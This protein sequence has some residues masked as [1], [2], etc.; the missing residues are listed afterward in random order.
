[1]THAEP[2]M[3]RAAHSSSGKWFVFIAVFIDMVGIGIAFPVLPILVGEYTTSNAEQTHWAIALS[4]VYSLMQFLCAPL[5]GAISDRFG[6]RIVLIAAIVG[7]GL[8]YVLIAHGAVA[9]DHAHRPHSWRGDR[10]ELFGRECLSRRH[11]AARGARQELRSHRR[12]VRPR[13]HLRSTARRR[14][15]ARS[16][17]ICRS[18]PR[19]DC[20]CS[21]RSTDFSSCRNR[22]RPSG[23][24]NS[25]SPRPI[26]S[27][28]SSRSSRTTQSEASSSSS[29]C[30]R[31]RI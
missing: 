12:R 13:I 4:V 30:L 2:A 21:M 23:A 27:A 29:R 14:A 11:L 1:M 7:L 25:R 15:R 9:L 18:T 8:H 31:S 17:C 20:R 24:E 26:R 6:R 28:P 3:S 5:L 22:F 19:R 10:R 16:I